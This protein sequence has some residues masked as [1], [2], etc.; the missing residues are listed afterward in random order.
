[1]GYSLGQQLLPPNA[2]SMAA[3]DIRQQRWQDRWNE[4]G[5]LTV[6][7]A[8][9][10]NMTPAK[11]WRHETPFIKRLKAAIAAELMTLTPG[12]TVLEY[13]TGAGH[14]S[15][16]V[17]E[18]ETNEKIESGD[19]AAIASI[20]GFNFLGIDFAVSAVEAARKNIS[21]SFK[22]RGLPCDQ[23]KL[24]RCMAANE[25]VAGTVLE[26]FS[27]AIIL[28]VRFL[29][30]LPE[31]ELAQVIASWKDLLRPGGIVLIAQ[32]DQ[33]RNQQYKEG[34]EKNIYTT[35]WSIREIIELGK[36]CGITL[37][38]KRHESFKYI[39]EEYGLWV[40]ERPY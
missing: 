3:Y 34:K 39:E 27:V 36:D 31:T 9:H 8:K 40:L 4:F 24:V 1:M 18:S 33:L 30:H 7:S 17:R 13:G 19:I 28:A 38:E 37:T 12:G 23:H 21:K 20:L 14:L 35:I 22:R 11:F 32:P 10:E 26:K 6:A 5:A 16:D 15:G 29:I 2:K 25:L